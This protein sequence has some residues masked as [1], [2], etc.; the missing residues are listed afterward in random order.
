MQPNSAHLAFNQWEKAGRLDYIISQNVDQ[1]HQKVLT[2]T[3][4][5]QYKEFVNKEEI[6]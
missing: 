3:K 6:S 2:C 1:L 5:N 4:S